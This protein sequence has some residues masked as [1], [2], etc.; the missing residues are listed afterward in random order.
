MR[1]ITFIALFSVLILTLT[2]FAAPPA[3][4]DSDLFSVRKGALIDNTT[5][6]DVNNIL[7]FVTNHGNFAR[8]LSG[9]FGYD[10]GTFF[11]YSSVADIES[12]A[13]NK[14]C[15]YASGLWIGGKNAATDSVQV[16]VAEYSDEYVPGPMVGGT[17][18]EDNAS[19]KVYK[20]YSDSMANNPND[21]WNNFPFDQGAPWT[22]DTASG[23]TIPDM[24]GDQM[25][26][27]VFNDADPDQ[28]SNSSGETAPMGIEV[29][30]TTFGFDRTGPLG[31]VIFL[32]LQV[33]NKG[34]NTFDSL[35]LSLWS[36]P[37]LGGAGDDFV[38]CDTTLSIGYVYNA[39]NSDQYYGST[40]PSVGYDFFQGPLRAT[41]LDDPIIG[42]MVDTVSEDPLVLDSTAF[43]GKAWGTNWIDSANFGM[44]SFNKYINGTDPDNFEETYNYMRG[45][46]RDGTV[47]TAPSGAQTRYYGAGDPVTGV[48]D[49]DIAPADRRFMLSTGPI[50]FAPGDSTEILAAIVV[51][52]GADRLSSISVM[53]YYDRFAQLA[54]NN[55]FV[56]PKPPA[57][58]IIDVTVIDEEVSLKWTDT[59]EVDPGDYPFEG[60]TVYQ[61]SSKTGPW[62]RVANYDL[63]NGIGVIFDEV[64]DPLSSALE[65]RAVKF[66]NDAGTRHHYIFTQ[67]QINGGPI[68]N[69]TTYYYKVEAYS[70][71]ETGLPK[72]L[73][74]E[75]IVEATPT[76]PVA[77]TEFAN[78]FNDT[79]AVT[80]VTGGSDGIVSPIVIDPTVFTGHTYEIS[81]SDTLGIVI[82]TVVDETADPPDTTLDST[83]IAWHLVDT[84]TGDSV[85]KWQTNQAGDEKYKIVDG[86]LMVVAGPPFGVKTIQEISNGSGTLSSPDN[87]AYSLNSTSDWYVSSDAG[88]DFTRMNWQGFIGTYDWEFRFTADST[89]YYDW[90]TDVLQSDRAPFEVW[91]IGIG[92]PEVTSDDQQIFF[93]FIDDDSSGA[94]SWGD[95]IYPWEVA[96]TEPAPAVPTYTWPTDFRI[97]R[98]E[99]NDY[100]EE[101]SAP[102]VG[103]VV[104]FT[105]NK[106]NTSEDVFTFTAEAPTVVTTGTENLDD[107]N[108]VPNPFYLYGPYDPTPGNYKIRFQHL[109]EQCTISIYNLA[110]DLVSTIDKDT[111]DPYADWNVQTENGL[112]VASGIYIYVVDAPGFGQKVGKMAVFTEVE[113]LDIY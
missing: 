68:R 80:H 85:L 94:W 78:I 75:T 106:V 23:D 10:A 90:N 37:D 13:Q 40:P 72:T 83:N 69:L 98:I 44:Y 74:S 7:M 19:F 42:Y 60:Y 73:T 71:L 57:S 1:K 18:Q 99:F 6:I 25:L 66:G 20:L 52:D 100:S 49:L 108:V 39:T 8:D 46:N 54:Y 36:D 26:W 86:F 76:P 89:E 70:Y 81:F 5:Y 4:R 111:P 14:W 104:R 87:V 102:A 27:A 58:P 82:D 2:S 31:N 30:Q 113:V 29:Q 35:F 32:K 3:N 77:G 93:S 67:D 101:L 51:G 53:K 28:H 45:L 112:P 109:P 22:I 24:I 38:G 43:Y 61:G 103:T 91:N 79:L 56:V 95:R 34:V 55:D 16:I 12:G 48:G 11:P 62:K 110:G 105:T 107:I 88:S 96:Y 33:Y 15:I 65:T 41:T 97:G 63:N 17:Y 21:D 9:L 84:N 59:S 47:Y 92:T 64:I 50:T